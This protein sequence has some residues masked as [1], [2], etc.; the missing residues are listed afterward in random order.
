LPSSSLTTQPPR[1]V[2]LGGEAFDDLLLLQELLG[3][4]S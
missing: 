2:A 3:E 4:R 1:R